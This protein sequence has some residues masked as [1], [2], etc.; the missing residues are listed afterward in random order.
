MN[1]NNK[2][3]MIHF[4]NLNNTKCQ[5][6]ML[7]YMRYFKQSIALAG[8]GVDTLGIWAMPSVLLSTSSL[9]IWKE[10]FSG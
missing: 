10:P 2:I 5:D 1:T 6:R 9:A 3:N 8:K 4:N 7:M